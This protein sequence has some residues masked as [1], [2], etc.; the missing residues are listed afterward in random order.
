M[1]IK[2]LFANLAILIST[3]FLYSQYSKHSHLNKKSPVSRKIVIGVLGGI[4]GIILM[5]YS[6]HI[7]ETLVD[8]RHIPIIL[9][10]YYAGTLPALIAM[11]III[12]GRFL[13]GVTLS[14]YF[15]LFF[16]IF[17]TLGA[18][19][20]SKRALSRNVKILLILS[21]SNLV[22]TLIF[23]YLVKDIEII[24]TVVPSYWVMSYIGGYI[25]FYIIEYLRKSQVLFERYKKESTIDGLTGLNNY[26]KFDE[27]YNHLIKTVNDKQEKLS[28]LYI[29]IDYFKKINDTYGHTQGDEVLKQIGEILQNYTRSF[30]IVSRN[31][32][33]EFTVLLLDC[34]LDKAVEKAELIRKVI[35]NTSFRLSGKKARITVSIGVACYSETTSDIDHIIEDADKALYQAKET[36]RNKVCIANYQQKIS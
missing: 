5:I 27:I 17:S 4:L 18:I 13:I 20:F 1:I 10:A 15:A 35:E 19:Y 31:G 21:W 23:L 7:G 25:G 28:L 29:D 33:E 2:D 30:D 3:L 9:L 22:S 16:V 24:Q 32:G 8:L 36:G 26:R 34:P 14:S 12:L 11:V 6:I